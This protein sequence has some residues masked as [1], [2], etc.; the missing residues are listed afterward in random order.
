MSTQVVAPIVCRN[1]AIADRRFYLTMAIVSTVIIF[2]GFS[3]SYYLKAHFPLSPALSPLV[4]LHGAVFTLWMLYFVLQTALIAVR[5]PKMHR[6]LGI[7]GLVL[8]C[9]ML[10]LGLTVA[11]MAERLGHGG[12][13][14]DAE[15]IFLVALIDLL[16]FTCFFLAGWAMRRNREAHQ[17]LMLIAVV[18]GLTGPG[19]GRLIGFGVPLSVITLVNFAL[20][21]AGPMYDFVTRRRVHPAYI[22]AVVHTPAWHHIAHLI[23]GTP[24]M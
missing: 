15:T 5:K 9:L 23:A 12:V 22:V 11:I 10:A 8:A 2:A 16:T 14:Q 18:F 6:N 19:L 7:F 4:H 3:R 20:F 1:H 21:F 13:G 24:A 17:R